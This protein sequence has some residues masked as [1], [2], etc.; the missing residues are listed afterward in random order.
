[1]ERAAGGEVQLPG[2]GDFRLF[3]SGATLARR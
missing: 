1:V 2:V 3:R